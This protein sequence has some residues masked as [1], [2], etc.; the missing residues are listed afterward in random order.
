VQYLNS[1]PKFNTLLLILFACGWL[2][3][4]IKESQAR[5]EWQAFTRA[6]ERFTAEDG[7]KL[8]ARIM[9]LEAECDI[10]E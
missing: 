7:A 6:G 4:E 5:V 9:V 3:T 8:K 2:Y 10:S 1:F